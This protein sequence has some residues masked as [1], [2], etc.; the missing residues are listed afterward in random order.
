MLYFDKHISY[1][2]LANFCYI[3]NI[4]NKLLKES[5][6]YEYVP[7]D[8]DIV[9]KPGIALSISFYVFK[10]KNLQFNI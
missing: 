4:L 9:K 10:T 3:I 2:R 7:S 5:K 1:E 6:I 8:Y